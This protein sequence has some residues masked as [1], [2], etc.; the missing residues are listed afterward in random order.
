MANLFTSS[1]TESCG[2]NNCNSYCYVKLVLLGESLNG[3]GADNDFCFCSKDSF[4]W[5][6]VSDWA[7]QRS[8]L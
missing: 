1:S 2:T 8:F 4:T 6:V 7:L 5:S 3:N